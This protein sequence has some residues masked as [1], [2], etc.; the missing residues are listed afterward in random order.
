[1]LNVGGGGAAIVV[2]QEA[3]VLQDFSKL[4]QNSKEEAPLSQTSRSDDSG[5]MTKWKDD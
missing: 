4:P 3:D 2:K 5:E 1:M